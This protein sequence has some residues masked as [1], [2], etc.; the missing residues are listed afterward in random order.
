MIITRCIIADLYMWN[1]RTT[2][3]TKEDTRSNLYALDKPRFNV[4][5]NEYNMIGWIVL[6]SSLFLKRDSGVFQSI[7]PLN[8]I[9]TS[10]MKLSLLFDNE[11][12]P[13]T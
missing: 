10:E 1:L 8:N 5:A 4:C 7:S 11:M 3:F 2:R 12:I 6:L 9:S 13:F